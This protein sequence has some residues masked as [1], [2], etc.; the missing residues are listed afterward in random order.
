MSL[1]NSRRAWEG[2]V[3]FDTAN[4]F[5]LGTIYMRSYNCSLVMKGSSSLVI[6]NPVVFSMSFFSGTLNLV[7]GSL[8]LT[9]AGPWTLVQPIVLDIGDPNGTNRVTLAGVIGGIISGRD[10]LTITDSSAYPGIL[11]L[12]S[13]NT[14]KGDTTIAS[15]TL[16]IGASGSISNTPTILVERRGTFDVS[17]VT[18]FNLNA[19][20]TLEGCGTV[21]GDVSIGSGANMA[22]GTTTKIGTLTNTGS[23]LLQSG[24]TNIVYV[25]NAQTGA[26][27]GN[28]SLKIGKNIGVLA[29]PSRPFTIKLIS[30]TSTGEEGRVSNFD[31]TMSY[32][33]TL[34]TGT[35]TNFAPADFVVDA[36]HFANRIDGGTFSVSNTGSALILIYKP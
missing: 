35:V 23:L 13:N 10:R 9:F 25:Q 4:A 7:G 29:T 12:E 31:R 2:T 27:V 16:A 22:G 5:G 32:R 34:A 20:Q 17:A 33:W 15:G 21:T 24:G 6:T 14:Y 1:G 8:G 19:G 3:Y 26:G 18:P 36:S 28:S 11:T 30:L